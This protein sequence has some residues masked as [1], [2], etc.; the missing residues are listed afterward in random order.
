MDLNNKK[1]RF[2]WKSQNLKKLS[3]YCQVETPESKPLSNTIIRTK[4]LL[5]CEKKV[6]LY[7]VQ[8]PIKNK[9]KKSQLIFFEGNF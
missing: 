3:G 2:T 6:S 7:D 4:E 5:V 9:W 1:W 8:F